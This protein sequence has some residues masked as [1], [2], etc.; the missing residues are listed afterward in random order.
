MYVTF[1]FG[2]GGRGSIVL[3]SGKYDV[4]ADFAFIEVYG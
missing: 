2:G 1:F 3:R 4:F